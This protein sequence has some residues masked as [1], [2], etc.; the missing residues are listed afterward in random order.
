MG[1]IPVIE[2]RLS[3]ASDVQALQD[4]N[5]RLRR[6]RDFLRSQYMNECEVNLRLEDTL[7]EHGISPVKG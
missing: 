7:R 5:E 3:K 1:W 4:E 2:V 6:E